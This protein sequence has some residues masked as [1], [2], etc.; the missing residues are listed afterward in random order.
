[1][2]ISF[3]F[4]IILNFPWWPW[5]ARESWWK[6]HAASIPSVVVR[7]GLVC[8]PFTYKCD[9]KAKERKEM[10]RE[11]TTQKEKKNYGTNFCIY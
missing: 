8:S 6:Y 3:P 1:M 4:S 10:L 2:A 7:H 9:H 11:K 5:E